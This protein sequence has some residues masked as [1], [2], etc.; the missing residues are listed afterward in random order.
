[1]P[2]YL[3]LPV[4]LLLTGSLLLSGCASKYGAQKTK[5]NYYPQ[6]YQPVNALRQDENSTGSSTAAGAVGG[7]LLGAIIG[8]LATG[9]VQGAVAGAAAGGAV[10]AVGGNIYGK[11]QAKK[12]DAAYLESYN[13]QLGTEAASM[14]R[15]TAAA[16][17]AAKCYDGQFKLAADQF[18]A[19]QISRLEFQ[20][21]YDE[22][23]SGLEET[24]YILGDTAATMARKD[25]EYR[26]A[27]EEPYTTA[28]PTAAAAPAAQK[29]R[30]SKP[31]RQASR[32]SN[33]A[34]SASEW[35]QSRQDLESTKND[36]DQRVTG[37][38]ETVKNLLG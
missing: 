13:R 8:G 6:C 5:V 1:M 18:R 26:E 16:K 35:K 38:D 17:V 2:R 34:A 3:Q 36:L 7:A 20:Q 25:G 29:A 10:G 23:R 4:L 33:V 19:G 37:Y 9:K 22:I 30:A 12:R 21:R 31:A 15:A 32:E 28:Q 11:S 27:L 24:S 14:N